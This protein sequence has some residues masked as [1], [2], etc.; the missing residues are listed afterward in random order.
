MGQSRDKWVTRLDSLILALQEVADGLRS[1]PVVVS[2]EIAARIAQFADE[3]RCLFC[4][5]Q[6]DGEARKGC[7]QVCYNK[8]KR[9]IS[10]GEITTQKAVDEGWLNPADQ[11]PGRKSRKPDPMRP[12]AAS[13]KAAKAVSRDARRDGKKAKTP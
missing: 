10:R 3:T 5:L 9:R 7:H 12:S 6:I 13:V 11:P 8:I 4:G 1:E 2:P